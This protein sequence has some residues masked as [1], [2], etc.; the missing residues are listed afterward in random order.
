MS[1]AIFIPLHLR[2]NSLRLLPIRKWATK[3]PLPTPYR[4]PVRSIVIVPEQPV[5]L[6]QTPIFWYRF[7][8]KWR[9]FI[10][11]ATLQST[12]RTSTCM[13]H[14]TFRNYTFVSQNYA[15]SNQK[16]F[17]IVTMKL[18]A[19]PYKLE[20]NTSN[21]KCMNW[22]AATAKAKWVKT[23][24]WAGLDWQSPVCIDLLNSSVSIRNMCRPRNKY[25]CK[26]VV[27]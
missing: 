23:L 27:W 22:A 5:V 18:L 14:S 19:E 16:S 8:W 3:L 17:K 6:R 26:H 10:R 2:Y 15:G 20:S 21:I 4:A 13:W 25:V 12:R 9:V 1:T 11:M 24:D 7:A